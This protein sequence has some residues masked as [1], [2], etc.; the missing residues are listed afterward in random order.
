[1][2]TLIRPRGK[3]IDQVNDSLEGAAAGYWPGVAGWGGSS[4]YVAL[5][6]HQSWTG[7]GISSGD[8][9][10]IMTAYQCVR[11]L[12]TTFAS[13]PSI[14]YRRREGARERADDHPLARTFEVAANPDMSAYDWKEAAKAHV[15]T[16]GNHYSDIV[17]RGD[18]S[19]ELWPIRPDRVRVY[20]RGGRKAYD[21][22]GSSG[23]TE[24][25][26]NRVFHLKALTT[27]GLVGIPPIEAMRRSL[28]LYRKA[29][30]YGES[31]FDNGA[32]PAGMLT[33]PKSLSTGAIQRLG[34][35]MDS[36]RGAGNAG[37]T[38]ILE[39]GADFKEVGFPPED[40]QFMETRLFQ[41][42]EVT[43]GF[44]VPLAMV[45][46]EVAADEYETSKKLLKW[47]MSP[48]FQAFEQ[49]AQ[50]QVIQDDQLYV[51]FLADAY[52]R[53]DPKAR[54]D[55]YAVAW[56]HGAL[57]SDE[58]RKRENQDPIPD[59]EGETYYVPANWSPVGQEKPQPVGGLT[60]VPSQFGQPAQLE[61][62]ALVT[63]TT[64]AND[65]K[66]ASAKAIELARFD[67]PDC[68]KLVARLAIP[69][70]VAWCKQCGG[71]RTMA[72]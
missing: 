69:G 62:A 22:L 30:R 23:V 58:W 46:E 15:E 56:E 65:T 45:G 35:Q 67:C 32:R 63:Q 71:E 44:G 42:R 40:A 6:D 31:V 60:S 33:H 47:T 14:L 61:P 59:G 4:G 53:A 34:A 66:L 41:K 2:K 25:D 68:G 5:R 12:A 52:L 17:R 55:A 51:E 36:L 20:W 13:I 72:S 29:E 50:L 48:S 24:L 70:T 16:W 19:V 1:M 21:Y 26:P 54:A 64:R 10:A 18:G 39:E 7:D 27:D 3:G 43:G 28:G 38:V 57:S 8:A 49:A 37:K 11:V 9:M